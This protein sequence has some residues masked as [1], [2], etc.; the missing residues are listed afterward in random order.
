MTISELAHILPEGVKYLATRGIVRPIHEGTESGSIETIAT[1]KGFS[2]EDVTSIV[3]ELN[4]L[5]K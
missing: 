3:A 4:E 5:V 1:E 2:P